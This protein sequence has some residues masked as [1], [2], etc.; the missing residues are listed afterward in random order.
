MSR[1]L[2]FEIA[3][4]VPLK[5]FVEVDFDNGHVAPLRSLGQRR[6]ILR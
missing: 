6:A 2:R 1:D 3:Q 4:A 5:T